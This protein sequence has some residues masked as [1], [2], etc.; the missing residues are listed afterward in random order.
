MVNARS[1]RT[2]AAAIA[3]A[4]AGAAAADGPSTSYLIRPQA[5]FFEGCFGECR[6]LVVWLDDLRGGFT[7]TEVTPAPDPF[8]TTYAVTNAKLST[9]QVGWVYEGNGRYKIG[10]DPALT[11]RLELDLTFGETAWHFDSSF[12]LVAGVPGPS[13]V[14]VIDVN[15]NHLECIDTVFS[16]VASRA[17]DWNA[18]GDRTVQDVFDFLADYFAGRG[19]VNGNGETSVEDIFA[20]LADFF[21][22][23]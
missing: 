8:F 2:I 22:P 12:V 16:I 4:C 7:L 20:F 13:P 23:V 14:I 1:I 21:E 18:S 5:E 15:R 3:L 6:C 10:G 17:S 19:D 11:N 9:P